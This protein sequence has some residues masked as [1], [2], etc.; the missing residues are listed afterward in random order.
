MGRYSRLLLGILAP[1]LLVACGAPHRATASPPAAGSALISRG[2]PAFSS[3]SSS[4][5]RY[6]NDD[7]YGSEWRSSDVPAWLAY[8][9][10]SVPAAKRQRVLAV[11]YNSSYAYSTVHGPHYNNWGSYTFEANAGAGGG[12]PPSSGWT[13]VT[14]VH[15]NT[16]HSRQQVLDL[17]GANWLRVSI[18]GSDGAPENTDASTN[19]FDVYD[20]GSSA[21]LPD[22]F[23]LFGDSITAEG[24]CP[25][26]QDGLPAVAELV[27][28]ADASRWPV[29]ENG[30]E[31]FDTSSNAVDR[32]LGP[33]GYLAAFP[34]QYVGL[35]YGM[36]DA[37]LP[38]NDGSYYDN[39]KHLVQAILAQ[40]KTPMIPTI[41]YTNDVGYNTNIKA[42][43]A[44]IEQ[45]YRE[46]PQI[47]PGPDFWTQFEKDS[48]LVRAGDIHLTDAGYAAMRRAW[49]A[50]LIALKAPVAAPET[51]P[52]TASPRS[53]PRSPAPAGLHVVGN[54]IRNAAGRPVRLLGVNHAGSEYACVGGDSATATG[55]AVFEPADFA[56]DSAALTTIRSWGANTIRI[57]LNEDCWLGISGVSPAFSGAKYQQ[58]IKTF[59]DSAK[60]SRL[61]VI[62]ELH[63][64]APGHFLAHGQAPMPDR[65][66]SVEM[67]REVAASYAGY[68]SVV[69]DLF[70]EP[71]PHWNQD[72]DDAW[73]CWR[74]GSA[75]D[76]PT[77]A[78]HCIGAEW[79]DESG[80]AFNGGRGYEYAAA[81]MQELVDAV[82]GAGAGNLI[83]LGGLQYAN[84]LRQWPQ[85]RPV[86]P[87]QNLAASWHSYSDSVCAT[88][89]C[90]DEQVAPVAAQVPLVVGEIGESDCAD[91]YLRPLMPWLDARAASYLAWTWNL[92][93]CEGFQLMTDYAS[94]APTPYG[95]AVH[96]HLKQIGAGVASPA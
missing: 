84:D 92:W 11:F 45:L 66:H 76:D 18:T 35:S 94:G 87:S 52:A 73:R 4:P 50:T 70:N 91:T 71:Y 69:F 57:G 44:K 58:A 46:F 33:N 8:D 29:V 64:S 24:M 83:L 68:G 77:N 53:G 7:D 23:V 56:A 74:D 32:L 81:G 89:S 19:M 39:M 86:D 3:A 72:T 82:R 36:N 9:L 79:W 30:G 65:D 28:S 1:A 40:G 61:A 13:T 48:G 16:L 95:R 41:S 25:C 6:A 14:S 54:E 49:A 17:A 88:S 22:D 51:A 43:N 26:S 38:G 12:K 67:W 42:Y 20:L 63:W 78:T 90:W 21:T 93:G 75:A 59:V 5:A 37:A 85:F 31:P 10:S 80:N 60:R 15:N 2:V 55:Y 47:V 96:D 34:G 62:L 27:H